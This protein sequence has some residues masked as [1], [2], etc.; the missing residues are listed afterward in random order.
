MENRFHWHHR[1]SNVWIRKKGDWVVTFEQV[2]SVE[3]LG[4]VEQRGKTA[5]EWVQFF[6]GRLE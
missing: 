4:T 3:P 6:V 5:Q 2:T 1:Y